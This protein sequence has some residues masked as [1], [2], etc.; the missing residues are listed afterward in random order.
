MGG[1]QKVCCLKRKG[2]VGRSWDMLGFGFYKKFSFYFKS[3]GVLIV[4]VFECVCVRVFTRTQMCEMVVVMIDLLV[5]YLYFVIYLILYLIMLLLFYE[6]KYK[7][8]KM[9]RRCQ[10]EVYIL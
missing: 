3:N 1:K 5:L 8:E 7:V 4:Y 2:E 9:K 6:K 10:W